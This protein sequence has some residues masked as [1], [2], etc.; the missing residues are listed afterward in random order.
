MKRSIWAVS[1]LTVCI[2]RRG[3]KVSINYRI[4]WGGRVSLFVR[5][6]VDFFDVG[7]HRRL[8]NAD[9]RHSSHQFT[10]A[11]IFAV[12][13]RRGDRQRAAD[14]VETAHAAAPTATR[15]WMCCRI[16]EVVGRPPLPIDFHFILGVR[17]WFKL[18]AECSDGRKEFSH[19]SDGRQP[20][21]LFFSWRHRNR[22][23]SLL[24]WNRHKWNNSSAFTSHLS[25]LTLRE[26]VRTA[27]GGALSTRTFIIQLRTDSQCLT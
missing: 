6:V 12:R 24:L 9:G 27:Q 3:C 22:Q 21:R 14:T 25:S 10:S 4:P 16:Q 13:W 7:R 17:F 2:E 15:L 8:D 11:I 5:I 20:A 26:R 23:L 18:T 19:A 1:L